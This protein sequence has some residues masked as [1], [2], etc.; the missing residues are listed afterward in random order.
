MSQ[1]QLS[2]REF[3]QHRWA[4][5]EASESIFSDPG[6]R[7]TQRGGWGSITGEQDRFSVLTESTVKRS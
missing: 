5:S 3:I 7:Y 6:T 4:G 2:F 1:R